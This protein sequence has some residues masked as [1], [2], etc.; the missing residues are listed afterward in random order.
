M[1]QR[2]TFR[3]RH[4]LAG[5]LVVAAF[6]MAPAPA[7]ATTVRVVP[8]GH[9]T[10]SFSPAPQSPA[11]PDA[12]ASAAIGQTT[13]LL[14]GAC[15][16]EYAPGTVV[17]FQAIDGAAGDPSTD[18]PATKFRRWSDDRCPS[19]TVHACELTV[20]STPL[21][22][23]ALFSPQRV[24]VQLAGA[25]GTVSISPPGLPGGPT[26]PCDAAGT[27]PCYADFDPDLSGPVT[28]T[29]VPNGTDVTWA[30]TAASDGRTLCDS[31]T[32]TTCTVVPAWPRWGS[33]GFGEP[34]NDQVPSAI[35]VDFRVGKAGSGS[36]TVR[37][38]KLDCGGRCSAEAGF[39]ETQTFTALPD[40]GSRFTGWRSACGN[41]ATCRLAVG[42]VTSLT[43]V[44]DKA[45]GGVGGTKNPGAKK[46]ESGRR[47]F[48]AR[49]LRIG[50]S[51]HGRR[52][53]LSIRLRVNDAATVRARLL[54]GRRQVAS[55]R[56]R[57]RRA[58][59]QV[60]RMRVP[61]RARPGSYRVRLTISGRGR[62]V[63]LTRGVRLRR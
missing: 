25:V 24:S 47:A 39:G 9:G 57:V 58:G 2:T 49:I 8:I 44:F 38:T 63:Q 37:S 19:G 6:G 33:V 18:D 51:G 22:V 30:P 12:C 52:R 53:T 42:P 17:R 35:T 7:R 45:A 56:W 20:G 31:T 36:G 5:A 27:A 55:H 10:V 61:A 43:A 1:T 26:L 4:L 62:T 16:V 11:A 32:D 60:L 40:D 34:P 48:A 59:V 23:A 28:L 14:S 54:R 3:T 15:V 50:V 29:A 21:T 13:D 41:A 46:R